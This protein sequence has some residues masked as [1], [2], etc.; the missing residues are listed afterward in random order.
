[1]FELAV[2]LWTVGVVCAVA[3]AYG[4]IVLALALRASWRTRPRR[5][6][7]GKGRR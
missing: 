2:V 7:D 5:P 6:W 4:L 1:M 3:L